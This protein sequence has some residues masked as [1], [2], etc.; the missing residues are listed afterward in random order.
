LAL[1][2]NGFANNIR[3]AFAAPF[4]AI[5][6]RHFDRAFA[7][8]LLLFEI[9]GWRWRFGLNRHGLHRGDLNLLCKGW[10]NRRR[11]QDEGKSE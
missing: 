2:L 11:G 1:L 3:H 8:R 5:A 7:L 4:A 6:T 10:N 9:A